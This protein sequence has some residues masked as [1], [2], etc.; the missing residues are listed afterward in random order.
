LDCID[1]NRCLVE[2]ANAVVILSDKFS[3]DA[4]HEDTHTILEAMIIKDYIQ[5][6]EISKLEQ[7]STFV[8][9]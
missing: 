6:K 2:K 3:L 4:E 7:F 9:M 8:C 1:L 5:K